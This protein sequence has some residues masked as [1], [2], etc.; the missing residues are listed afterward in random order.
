MSLGEETGHDAPCGR[1]RSLVSM[2][3]LNTLYGDGMVDQGAFTTASESS[4]MVS[5]DRLCAR[6][7]QSHTEFK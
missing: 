7:T 5:K 1:E 2:Q 3:G 4:S 6:A